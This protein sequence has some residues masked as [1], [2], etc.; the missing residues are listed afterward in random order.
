MVRD[1]D[2]CSQKFRDGWAA[3]SD[4]I[5]TVEDLLDAYI[6][7]YNDCISKI[8]DDMHVGIHLCRGNF[9]GGRH[10]AEGAYDIIAK[11]LFQELNVHTYY[12]EYDT[13]RA[14]GFEPLRHLPKNKNVVVGIISTKL[15]QVEAKEEMKQRVY[16]AA[17]FIAEGINQTRE[18]ALKRVCVSPQCG[19]STHESGYPLIEEQEKAKLRLVRQIADEI[20]GEP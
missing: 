11:K 20:W 3:D 7:L 2:F 9:I 10:F 17:D 19:F 12:L 1:L 18:E 14:G 6:K 5:G 8:P 4:N 16:K 13:E 15:P